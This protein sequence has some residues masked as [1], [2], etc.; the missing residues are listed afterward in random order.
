MTCRTCDKRIDITTEGPKC[1]VS[2]IV[3]KDWDKECN[4]ERKDEK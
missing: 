2:G 3:I 1:P 4:C